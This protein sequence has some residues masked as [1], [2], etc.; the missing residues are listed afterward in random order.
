MDKIFSEGIKRNSDFEEL[1]GNP[2]LKNLIEEIENNN[3][4]AESNPNQDN[5]SN[6]DIKAETIPIQNNDC[7]PD[8]KAETISIPNPSE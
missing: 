2:K 1:I 4:N 6:P 3:L 8:I 7:N 5:N